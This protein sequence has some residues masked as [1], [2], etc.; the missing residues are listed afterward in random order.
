MFI[1]LIRFR[2]PVDD[3]VTVKRYMYT[4]AYVCVAMLKLTSLLLQFYIIKA[5]CAFMKAILITTFA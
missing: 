4:Q 3:K 2:K 5:Y 1:I